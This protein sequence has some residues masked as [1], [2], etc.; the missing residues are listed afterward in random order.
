MKTSRNKQKKPVEKIIWEEALQGLLAIGMIAFFG[1]IAI[2]KF[3]LMKKFREGLDNA[4]IIPDNWAFW[5]AWGTPS[6]CLIITGVL[7]A[8]F[9]YRRMM[10]A[11]IYV[12]TL[13]M[14]LFTAFVAYVIQLPLDKQPCYCIGLDTEMAWETHLK[15]NIIL[16]LG[17]IVVVWL[18]H[19]IHKNLVATIKRA[20]AGGS[21]N[22]EGETLTNQLTIS[23]K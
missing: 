12:A 13:F 7:L 8:G 19:R 21:L 22:K 3:W 10:T 18:N 14:V 6:I 1:Y 15:L 5:I 20:D 2:D 11:G 4:V 17:T 16:L 23:T 9:W